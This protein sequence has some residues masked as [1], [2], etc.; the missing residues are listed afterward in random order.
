MDV[1]RRHR[2]Y[3]LHPAKSV[4]KSI[5]VGRECAID[6]IHN[7]GNARIILDGVFVWVEATNFAATTR[8]EGTAQGGHAEERQHQLVGAARE[9]HPS[10][11][12]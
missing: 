7:S 9:S 8:P 12:L 4:G 11:G 1:V 6:S 10:V 5:D 3:I 2:C